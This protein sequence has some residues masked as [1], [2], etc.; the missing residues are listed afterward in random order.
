MF[1]EQTAPG[2]ACLLVM[3]FVRVFH[4]P[5][6]DPEIDLRL[7]FFPLALLHVRTPFFLGLPFPHVTAAVAIGAT[8][9][10]TFLEPMRREVMDERSKIIVA[11]LLRRRQTFVAYTATT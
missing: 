5:R 9:H 6:F 10:L 1:A 4:K 7:S 11:S 2:V 8:A 3:S